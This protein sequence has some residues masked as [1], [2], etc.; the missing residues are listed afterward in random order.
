MIDSE[1]ATVV[2]LAVAKVSSSKTAEPVREELITA[3]AKV[4]VEVPAS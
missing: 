1:V 2:A 4:G 3:L